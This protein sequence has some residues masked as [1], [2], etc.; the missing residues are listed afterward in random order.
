[1]MEQWNNGVGGVYSIKTDR[2]HLISNIPTFQFSIQ[3][4]EAIY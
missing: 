2:F 1:M 4:A 3:M